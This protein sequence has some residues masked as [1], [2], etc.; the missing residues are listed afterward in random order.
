MC[1]P[2][3]LPTPPI[4]VLNR[5]RIYERRFRVRSSPIALQTRHEPRR[6]ELP[7]NAGAS[8]E[9]CEVRYVSG[10]EAEGVA[11]HG[12]TAVRGS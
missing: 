8:C 1:S 12:E 7:L 9:C 2:D 11:G 4:R 10:H 6:E 3:A 5:T